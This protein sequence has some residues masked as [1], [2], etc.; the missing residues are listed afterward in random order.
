MT[1]ECGLCRRAAVWLSALLP[2]AA[3]YLNVAICMTHR[4]EL[5]RG[6]VAL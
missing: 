3:V 5:P 2:I 1:W 6:A 4:P